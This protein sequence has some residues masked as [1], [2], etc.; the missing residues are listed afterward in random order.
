MRNGQSIYEFNL[1]ATESRISGLPEFN[2]SGGSQSLDDNSLLN[3][4]NAEMKSH[5]DLSTK[6]YKM[7]L[8]SND[9]IGIVRKTVNEH[10]KQSA[11]E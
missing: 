4:Q 7:G 6:I 11:G 8:F 9:C 1:F 10:F 2:C 3:M 5:F